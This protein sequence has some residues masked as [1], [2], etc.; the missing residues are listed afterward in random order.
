MSIF[1]IGIIASKARFASPPQA[2]SP[3]FGAFG[4]EPPWTEQIDIPDHCVW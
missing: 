1:F 4:L 2:A 3:D